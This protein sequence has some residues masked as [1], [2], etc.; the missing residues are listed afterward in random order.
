[1][2]ISL[3]FF[4]LFFFLLEGDLVNQTKQLTKYTKAQAME[5]FRWQTS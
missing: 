1:M 4:I 3:G 5:P 2:I